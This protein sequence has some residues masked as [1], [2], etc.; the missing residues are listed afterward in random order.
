MTDPTRDHI[1][2]RVAMEFLCRRV[3]PTAVVNLTEIQDVTCAV[4]ESIDL[5]LP[6]G[7]TLVNSNVGVN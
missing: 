3:C 1:K 7:V 4:I 2:V 6:E 5:D